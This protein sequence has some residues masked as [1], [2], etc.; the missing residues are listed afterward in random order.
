MEQEIEALT[1]RPLE[2]VARRETLASEIEK[3]EAQRQG[4]ADLLAAGETRLSEADRALRSQEKALAGARE[5]QVR[6]ESALALAKQSLT[7]IAAKVRERL[8]CDLDGALEVAELDPSQEPPRR[9]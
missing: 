4:A 6:A 9:E 5:N 3:A 7:E 8:G 1:A 2:L